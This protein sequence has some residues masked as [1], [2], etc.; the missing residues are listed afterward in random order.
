MKRIVYISFYIWL[1]LYIAWDSTVLL[2]FKPFKR[3][4]FR[5]ETKK[6]E[7]DKQYNPQLFHAKEDE[8][9][10]LA[11]YE[12][13]V[14]QISLMDNRH[15][16]IPFQE[17]DIQRLYLLT[18]GPELPVFEEYLSYYAEILTDEVV[19][20]TETNPNYLGYF[21]PIILAINGEV[22]DSVIQS[23]IQ[24]LQTKTEVV[25]VNFRNLDVLQK[26]G[27]SST[28]LQVYNNDPISQSLAAQILFGGIVAKGVVPMLTGL[29]EL[30]EVGDM[31]S[32]TRLSYGFPELVGI[33][34]RSLSMIDSIVYEGIADSAMPGC[35]VLLARKG[36]VI[37]Q[38]AFGTHTYSQ[39]SQV[40][41][42]NHLYDIASVTKVAATTLAAMK[43][44]E[45]GNLKLNQPLR[46]Y[47][48]YQL[49]PESIRVWDT[50]SYKD[51][52]TQIESSPNPVVLS[53]DDTLR[54]R[55]TLMLLGRWE[56]KGNPRVPAIFDVTPLEL[57]T[58]TSG[59]QPSL[60]LSGF[61]NF[62]K[63]SSVLSSSYRRTH[64]TYFMDYTEETGNMVWKATM[65]LPLSPSRY[66]Y[67]DVNM[68]LMRRLIDSLS[69]QNFS[70]YLS[71]QFY[72]K[73]GLQYL[74]FNPLDQFDKEQIVPTEY[75]SKLDTLIHGI[76][77]DP[78]AALM[79]GEAG[80]AGLFSNANDLAVIFQM[81]LNGGSYG[82]YQ[83]LRPETISKF[84]ANY[85]YTRGLGFD[86]P[87]LDRPY[88]IARSAS[89]QTFGHTGFTGTCVW[90][91]PEHDIVYV[92][93]SNRV[94]PSAKNR[95]L[96]VL[97]I[98][99]RIHQVIYDALEIP[100]RKYE[101]RTEYPTYF[102]RA[103]SQASDNTATKLD[104]SR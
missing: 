25:V 100:P 65:Q 66:Q 15:G 64:S 41:S 76:V 3:A 51:L 22:K 87:P 18:I 91:D 7:Y 85:G 97:R 57:L 93:L 6:L 35:Q 19:S 82:G 20:V 5:P 50:L 88:I 55:D 9:N 17:L 12:S 11:A 56:N 59:L 47:F 104:D 68:M 58:H 48:R 33:P 27:R 49:V 67:S 72:R 24:K 84:T 34:S 54:Y 52:I 36:K 42:I 29:E 75:N 1:G 73:L 86:K 95:R 37:Y 89:P 10:Q 71:D 14:N 45:N 83:Y 103:N 96:Q 69:Q 80:H 94:H 21:S 74:C 62:A 98:R 28:W 40:V 43:L 90:A 63:Q 2:E 4:K 16:I 99:E 30:E 60:S 101:R 79:G 78:V 31:T 32:I 77:H 46:K 92:F 23:F 44:Y 81:L 38:K 61:Y 26:T 102:T 53:E 13:A 70:L 39:D 8:I